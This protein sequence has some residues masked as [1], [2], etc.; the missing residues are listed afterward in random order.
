[1]LTLVRADISSLGLGGGSQVEAQGRL[2]LQQARAELHEAQQQLR[3]K[4][5][6]LQQARSGLTHK[7]QQVETAK[8]QVRRCMPP[9]HASCSPSQ[10]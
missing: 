7:Q 1:V 4:T 10:C 8:S 9:P 3:S 2:R 6:A 5:Q